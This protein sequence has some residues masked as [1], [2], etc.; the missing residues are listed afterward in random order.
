MAATDGQ[1]LAGTRVSVVSTPGDT[2]V[3][4]ALA[5]FS[6]FTE[7][8]GI[9]ID[10]TAPQNYHDIIDPARGEARLPASRSPRNR[11]LWVPSA[12][13]ATSSTSRLTSIDACSSATC[14]RT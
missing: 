3:E 12:G 8:T 11:H 6:A 9:Q 4:G 13:T 14:P 10:Y 1:G 5:E 2:H 7:R